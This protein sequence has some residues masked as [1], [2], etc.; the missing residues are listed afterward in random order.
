MKRLELQ[1]IAHALGG[2]PIWATFEG[3]V[4]HQA[5]LRYGDIILSVNG[6]PTPTVKDYFA[7]KELD[8][9]RI[10]LTYFRGGATLTLT[11][12]LRPSAL[13]LDSVLADF[14]QTRARALVRELG[15]QSN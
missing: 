14:V 15:K 13:K 3:S 9:E 2:I 5:G 12:A 8:S 10:T 7:A 4:A 6:K 11:L 1:Q